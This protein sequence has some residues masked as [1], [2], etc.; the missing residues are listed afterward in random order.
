MGGHGPAHSGH[1][2]SNALR[3]LQQGCAAILRT[4]CAVLA[5]RLYRCAALPGL[6]TARHSGATPAC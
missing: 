5:N 4:D 1:H 2:G 6:F 3:L